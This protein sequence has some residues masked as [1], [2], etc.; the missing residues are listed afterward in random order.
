MSTLIPV[1]AIVL[2]L[3]LIV[4]CIIAITLVN[5]YNNEPNLGK[6]IHDSVEYLMTEKTK[7][8]A[9][10]YSEERRLIQWIEELART[11]ILDTSQLA[12]Q[13]VQR[14][15]ALTVKKAEDALVTAETSLAETKRSITQLQKR[16]NDE[17]SQGYN[18]SAEKTKKSLK[19]LKEQ[20][21]IAEQRVENERKKLMSLTE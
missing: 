16:L 8:I 12:T 7:E 3:I 20:E 19:D 21:K 15:Y 11:G 14:A 1:A 4:L 6:M 5:R 9:R 13:T 10:A 2:V 17:I 18:T